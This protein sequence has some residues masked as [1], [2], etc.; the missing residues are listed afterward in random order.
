MAEEEARDGTERALNAYGYSLSQV[1]SFKYL[2]R[3]ITVEDDDF[4]AVVRDLRHARQKWARMNQVLSKEGE[5]ARTLGQIYWEVV[6]SVLL[7]GSETWILPPRMKR[8]LGGFHDRVARIMTGQKLR[9]GRDRG[10]VYPPL[11]D[12]MAE[13]DL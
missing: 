1:T 8:V 2:G 9:K 13:A 11:E 6:Q 12:A 4:P 7:Y 3:V 5:D 10:W